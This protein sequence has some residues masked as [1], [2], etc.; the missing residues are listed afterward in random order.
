MNEQENRFLKLAIHEYS[1]SFSTEDYKGSKVS[2]VRILYL[3]GE[4]SR[5]VGNVDQAVKYLSMVIEKQRNTT[6]SKLIE[7]AKNCW[8]EIR[9][10]K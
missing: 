2:E 8:Q 5:R 10:Q 7:M 6:E 4:L 1:E 3:L 9:N